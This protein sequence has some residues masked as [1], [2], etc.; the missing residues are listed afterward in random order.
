MLSPNEDLTLWEH[1]TFTESLPLMS[2]IS[3][4]LLKMIVVAC[5]N[6]LDSCS[7]QYW[8]GYVYAY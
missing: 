8:A 2:Q 1:W 7:L 6:G 4:I 5:N 3:T